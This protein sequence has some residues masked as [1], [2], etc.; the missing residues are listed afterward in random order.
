MKRSSSLAD[1]VPMALH[2]ARRVA[3]LCRSTALGRTTVA[4]S[5]ATLMDCD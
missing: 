5:R 2:W 3:R 1:D 4:T